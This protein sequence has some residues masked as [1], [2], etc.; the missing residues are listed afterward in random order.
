MLT[1]VFF[2]A[3]FFAGRATFLAGL[4][5]FACAVDLGCEAF[6]FCFLRR[7]LFGQTEE[8]GHR[9]PDARLFALFFQLRLAFNGEARKRN[10]LE[11]RMRNRFPRHFAN[12]VRPELDTFQRLIN[13][14]E[15]V[16]LLGKQTKGEVAIVSI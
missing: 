4:A 10:C 5:V 9:L 2:N 13:L 15:R 7:F 6:F 16:L 8:R 12:T 1:T 3:C 11:A 14:V